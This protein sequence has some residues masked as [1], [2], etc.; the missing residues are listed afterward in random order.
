MADAPGSRPPF[1]LPKKKERA[2]IKTP[3]RFMCTAGART[4]CFHIAIELSGVAL[5]HQSF[6]SQMEM[7]PAQ[8]HRNNN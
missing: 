4:S 8:R 7:K 2:N 1:E 5:R 6:R 3:Q